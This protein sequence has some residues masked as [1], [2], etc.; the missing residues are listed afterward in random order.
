MVNFWTN[1]FWEKNNNYAGDYPNINSQG[2]RKKCIAKQIISRQENFF[3]QKNKPNF[4]G[5]SKPNR[6]LNPSAGARRRT[7]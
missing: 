3:H 5:K 4:E 1:N 2:K 6:R 7:L